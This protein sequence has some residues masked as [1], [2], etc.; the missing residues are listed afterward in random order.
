MKKINVGIIGCG[1]IA[2]SYYIPALSNHKDKIDRVYFVDRDL[3]LANN[4]KRNFGSG[5]V[6][7]D[8]DKI[9]DKLDAGVVCLPNT[10][11][12]SFSKKLLEAGCHVMGEKPLTLKPEN[13]RELVEIAEKKKVLLSV[14]NT[15]RLFPSYQ[16]VKELID[17]GSIGE[18]KE[19]YYYEGGEF[20]WPT[21][22]GFY[23]TAADPKGVLLDRGAHV[24]DSICHWVGGKPELIDRKSVV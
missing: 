14:N 15:R 2:E 24:L 8:L 21:K 5:E 7:D 13:G 1:A 4:A 12:Y 3:S 11:H 20:S 18:I 17:D 19:V 10:L 9:I 22:S 23:F 6:S 16:V